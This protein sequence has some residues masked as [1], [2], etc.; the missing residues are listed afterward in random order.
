MQGKPAGQ[1]CIPSTPAS[2][3][4]GGQLRFKPIRLYASRHNNP[5]AV[6]KAHELLRT[7]NTTARLGRRSAKHVF[8]SKR[9]PGDYMLLYLNQAPACNQ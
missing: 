4:Q 3:L 5:G 7:L 9:R 8:V 1:L 6:E 2:Q